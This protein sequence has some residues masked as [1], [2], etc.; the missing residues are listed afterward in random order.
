MTQVSYNTDGLRI[1]VSS[2]VGIDEYTEVF[3]SSPIA[4]QV[5]DEGE[6]YT[7][8]KDSKCSSKHAVYKVIS[9]GWKDRVK[10]GFLVV[11]GSDDKIAEYLVVT[12]GD[13]VSVL[14]PLP[15]EILEF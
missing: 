14:S 13:C 15:P 4:F 9:G 11:S 2:P 10:N 6:M 12:V 1:V 7:L 8:W 5:M 3:F